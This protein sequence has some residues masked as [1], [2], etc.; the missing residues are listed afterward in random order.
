MTRH[1]NL[2]FTVADTDQMLAAARRGQTP[3]QIA[4]T[5]RCVT[6]KP[7]APHEVERVLGNAG[8]SFAEQSA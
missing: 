5:V 3:T 4:R 6:G 1:L 8:V 2:K 7:C